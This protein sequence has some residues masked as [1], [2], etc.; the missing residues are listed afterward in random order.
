MTSMEIGRKIEEIQ[1]LLSEIENDDLHKSIERLRDLMS[2]VP[3]KDMAKALEQMEAD[4]GKMSDRLDRT[5][6]LLKRVLMDQK[7]EEMV[8]RME[9][10]LD[11]QSA[12]RDSTRT[13][14]LE[15]LSE[16]QKDLTDEYKRFEED[17]NR[18]GSELQED[19]KQAGFDEVLD[20]MSEAR[21]DSL[22]SEAYSR[23]RDQLRDK[24]GA[25]QNETVDKMTSLYT[26]LGKCQM[27]MSMQADKETIKMVEDATREII[28]VSKLQEKSLPLLDS[29][30]ASSGDIGQILEHQNVVRDAVGKIVEKLI[31]AGRKDMAVSNDVFIHLGT[32][33]HRLNTAIEDVRSRKIGQARVSMAK[34]PGELNLAA[35]ELLRSGM[36]SGGSGGSM[37]QQ[38]QM[39][40]ER[41]SS[42]DDQLKKMMEDAGQEQMSMRARSQMARLAAEQRQLGDMMKKMMEESSGAGELLGRLGDIGDDMKEIASE[43]EK[44]RLDQDLT[45]RE[46]RILSRML[47]SQR[48]LNRRDYSRQRKSTTAGDIRA[49]EGGE[50][51]PGSEDRDVLL[52]RIRNAMREKGP[53]EYE[54]LIRA[55]F[56]ALSVKVRDEDSQKE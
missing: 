40:T 29:P 3:E 12:L 34:V 9:S 50:R 13:G 24:A 8:R 49:A 32:A 28:E 43:L 31:E 26:R 23:L 6:E 16:R 41:Q 4:A 18:F 15:E 55:Y 53:A 36:S 27:V 17:M 11:D 44:G 48:S 38:M 7:M 21:I 51:P 37:Q 25:A 22:M 39:M 56:R 54:E 20:K 14:D 45:R 35:V 47:E 42:I 19:K 5:I 52:E 46:E 2:K 30:G 1:K 33:V 10:M